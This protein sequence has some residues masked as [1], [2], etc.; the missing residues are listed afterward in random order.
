MGGKYPA[1]GVGFR[2]PPGFLPSGVLSSG[3]EARASTAALLCGRTAT[4]AHLCTCKAPE[5]VGQ[6]FRFSLTQALLLDKAMPLGSTI[7][8]SDAPRDRTPDEENSGFEALT[9]DHLPG[10]SALI[11]LS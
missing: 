1:K 2:A 3:Y 8:S 10:G 4:P 7:W 6:H 5:R 11:T 9:A